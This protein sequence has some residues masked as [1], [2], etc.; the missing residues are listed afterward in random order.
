MLRSTKKLI[1]LTLGILSMSFLAFSQKLV[2]NKL[3]DTTICFS[4]SQGKYL[5]KQT[6]KA[7]EC[8]T[9]RKICETQLAISDSVISQ[10]SKNI[11][12]YKT[13]ITNNEDILW[14]KND[15]ISNLKLELSNEKKATRQQRVYKWFAIVGGGALSGVIF[16]FVFL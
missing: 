13:L 10:Q 12:N 9:L 8:D 5:L 1:M 6:Y 2:L 15:Q 11:A 7:L 4:L 3:G 14:V 16:F